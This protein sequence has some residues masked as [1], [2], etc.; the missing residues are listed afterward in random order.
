VSV[1]LDGWYHQ[2][3]MQ[4][5]SVLVVVEFAFSHQYG[6]PEV[7]ALSWC[8]RVSSLLHCRL[9]SSGEG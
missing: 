5:S 3:F 9:V 8:N 7:E 1:T 2:V 4:G 6:R